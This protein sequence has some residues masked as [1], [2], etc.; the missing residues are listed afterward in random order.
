MESGTS[1]GAVVFAIATLLV[2][3][4]VALQG[5]SDGRAVRDGQVRHATLEPGIPF[6]SWGA[7]AAT[8]TWIG[9]GSPPAELAVD[10]CFL[11]LGR[12]DGVVV[13]FDPRSRRSIR[14]PAGNVLVSVDGT[15]ND[16]ELA[17]KA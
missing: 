1:A 5:W 6:S 13:L 15:V 14:V 9:S 10:P 3:T 12:A 7:D 2:L 4:S 17:C 11:Y 16:L 8:I